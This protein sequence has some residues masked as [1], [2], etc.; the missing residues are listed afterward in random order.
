MF[1]FIKRK[2]Y[3]A[4]TQYNL[5]E[6]H[7]RLQANVSCA[8]ARLSGKVEV[9]ENCIIYQ[10]TIAGNVEIG[11]NTTLW[12]P[13]IHVVGRVE[14]VRIGSF[15]SIARY[16]SVQED[17]HDIERTTSY[18]IEKNV[19][20][21][22]PPV[23]E[24]HSRGEIRIGHDVW[25]GAGAQVLSGVNVGTGAV[26]GAGA[27]VTHDVPPY[28]IVGGNPARVIRFRFSPSVVDALLASAWWDWP[29]EKILENK[30][31]LTRR[32]T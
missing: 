25:I 11:R 6:T 2:L 12:G 20:K 5:I 4:V 28:A 8:G 23:N 29:M 19:F 9:G 14:G 10:A 27:I 24:Y 31:F 15:C 21:T 32:W 18:F 13:G 30:A 1:N 3:D 26:I 7:C 17:N 16:V 22:R